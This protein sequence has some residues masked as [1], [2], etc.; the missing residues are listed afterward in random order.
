MTITLEKNDS[1]WSNL[2]TE[3]TILKACTTNLFTQYICDA[4]L[5]VLKP[6]VDALDEKRIELIKK[7]GELRDPKDENS[8]YVKD[9]DE[10]GVELESFKAFKEEFKPI[11]EHQTSLS[12]EC[13]DIDMLKKENPQDMTKA[14]AQFGYP[15][16][17]FEF[18]ELFTL[19]AR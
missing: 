1:E 18:K 2:S 11:R 7:H 14:F 6:V 5:R 15:R 17:V 4:I 10:Q 8:W 13:M 3:V 16:G 9:V 19:V 12:V